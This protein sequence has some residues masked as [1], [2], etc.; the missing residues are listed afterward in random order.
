MRYHPLAL[1]AAFVSGSLS[2][3]AL[4]IEGVSTGSRMARSGKP[5]DPAADAAGEAVTGAPASANSRT[6]DSPAQ[7]VE[8]NP[9][10]FT[11]NVADLSRYT[12]GNP[13]L[14]GMYSVEI[15]I[16]GRGFGKVDVEFRAVPGKDTAAPCFSLTR[17]RQLGIDTRRVVMRL[18]GLSPD[19]EIDD[20][21]IEALADT[22]PPDSC[23]PL[24]E[25]VPGATA[26]FDTADLKLDLSV[27]Q[28]EMRRLPRGYVEPSQW[29]AGINAGLLQYNLSTYTTHQSQASDTTSA[30][31]GL[32]AGVNLGGWRFRQ[33]SSLNWQN[34][35][36]ARW[37]SIAAYAQHDLT[38]LRSQ[39]TLG[40]SYTNGEIFDAFSV[41][42]V[43]LSSDDR[44][45]PDSMRSYAPAVRGVAETNARVVVRQNNNILYETSVPPGPFELN[46]LPA[47]GYGGDLEVTIT[48]ADGRSRRFSVPFASVTQLLRPGV[49]RFNVTL[50]QYRDSLISGR[51]MVAQAT[52]QRG[53]SDLFT[54]YGGFLGANGYASGLLGIALNTQ[55]G[56]VALDATLARTNLPDQP[57]RQGQSW[58][59]SYSKLMPGTNTNFTMAAYRYSTSGF[60]SLRDAM[61]AR[62]QLNGQ[63]G[64]VDGRARSRVQLNISQ[65]V[66]E[67]SSIYVAASS[68]NY[69][70]GARGT[71]L[72]YQLGFSGAFKT[73]SYTVYAQRSRDAASGRIVTQVGVNVSLPLGRDAYVKRNT[74]DFVTA[75]LTQGSNATSNLQLTATGST[76]GDAPISYGVSAAR[77]R[78]GD[79]RTVSLGGFGT[80]RSAYG[81]YSANASIGDG[82]RQASLNAD[83]AVVAHVGGITL[84]PPL[85]M[86]AAL[87]E[88]KGAEGAAI[89][90]GQ[91]ARIDHNGYALLPSLMPYRVNTVAV[92]PSGMSDE[93]E[94]QSTSE[95]VVPRADALTLVRIQTTQGRPVLA[96]AEDASGNGLPMGAELLNASG[97]S[98]GIVGQGGMAFLRGV[99]GT[100]VLTA[101]W[102]SGATEQCTLPYAIS[103]PLAGHRV[104]A[105]TRVRLRCVEPHVAGQ[106]G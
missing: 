73:V 12:R 82:T 64:L 99:E 67:R 91:G 66:G 1:A 51:P 75:N 78:N 15:S 20:R 58:R 10:F 92:D 32:Q 43:Q 68:Q 52:Y 22:L 62:N 63:G 74:F 36:G 25:A 16:N 71:D 79:S 103:A 81:T 5:S 61:Y 30:F 106:P 41:R 17:L 6:G 89:I 23:I 96:T 87:V 93:V 70:D 85:G 76:A 94:L 56:A 86:A 35:G 49:S 9:A 84:G 7:E 97:K 11:G 34:T 54:A 24:H 26:A 57:S 90:N 101:R 18:K 29:D 102:G 4:A 100:G 19:G 44:M 59:L 31:L 105:L 55:V 27:P 80:Y 95:E 65:P 60:Y 8:F 37:N 3:G 77:N 47:T 42:G 46:D 72:Q 21:G 83:G 98:M 33:R 2:T 88:A 38:A 40:D 28:L 48:E 50:G 13:I 69:W 53:L 104:P 14:P 45:L 39:L